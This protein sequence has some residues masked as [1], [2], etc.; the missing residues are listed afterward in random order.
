MEFEITKEN[1][2]FQKEI[3]LSLIETLYIV[4]DVMYRN[5]RGHGHFCCYKSKP[6][7]F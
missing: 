3:A 7:D 5:G 6:F 2:I 4:Y 1:K